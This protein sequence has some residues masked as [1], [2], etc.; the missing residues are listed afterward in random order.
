MEKKLCD[1]ELGAITLKESP[2]SKRYSLKISNGQIVATM[3]LYGDENKMIAFINENRQKL[4]SLLE[5]HPKEQLFNESTPIQTATFR[6]QITRA[7]RKD[8]KVMLSEGILSVFCPADT[9]FEEEKVQQLLKNILKNVCR[10]EAKRVLPARLIQLARQYKFTCTGV[11]INSSRTHWGSCTGQKSINLS[12]S[13]MQLPW[14]LIDYVLLHELCHT[15]EMNHSERFWN[16]MDQVTNNK[17]L[18][19]RKELKGYSI[20]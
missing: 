13:L 17:A 4:L 9:N 3:P 14:H 5:K 18:Q 16:L 11:K 19:L 7:E 6:M 12:L 2:R 8:F 10:H 1:N 20:L 15:V